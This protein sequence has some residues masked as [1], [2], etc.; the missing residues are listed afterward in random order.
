MTLFQL[1]ISSIV[2]ENE[3][4]PIRIMIHSVVTEDMIIPDSIRPTY[5]IGSTIALR[6]DSKQSPHTSY[7]WES[8]TLTYYASFG[9]IRSLVSIP[10]KD[11][12]RIDDL[13]HEEAVIFGKVV[14]GAQ[15]SVQAPAPAKIEQSI[16]GAK[17]TAIKPQLKS[18]AGE[19]TSDTHV[20]KLTLVK[21]E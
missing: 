11:I 8:N 20:G 4:F 5:P 14:D 9:G 3:S 6:I 15:A 10:S 16:T 17:A 18:H 1:L 12:V 21:S 7:D 13:Y 19:R 2:Q